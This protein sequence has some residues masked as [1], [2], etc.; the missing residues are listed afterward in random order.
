MEKLFEGRSI[1]TTGASRGTGFEII[2]YL[3]SEGAEVSIGT[4]SEERF[5]QVL[6]A[7]QQD[8][9]S[10]DRKRVHPF[11]AD[12][13]KNDQIDKAF[14]SLGKLNH[15][16]TDIIHAAA[17]G[18]P[19]KKFAFQLARLA[20]V[21][22]EEREERFQEF[23]ELSKKLVEEN[24]ELSLA[25]NYLG[26]QHL[27]GLTKNA[28]QIYLSSL[29]ATFF[30]QVWAP[31]FYEVISQPKERTIYF[32]EQES[33]LEKNGVYTTI[34]SGHIIEDT[35]VGEAFIRLVLPLMPKD[36]QKSM[37]ATFITKQD[38]VR[39]T[40]L[41]LTGECFDENDFNRRL[42]VFGPG[43]QITTELSADSPVFDY[44]IPI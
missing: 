38:M 16:I 6:Q 10:F 39:A 15:P 32:L 28:N 43:G 41:A 29:Y 33:G 42:F 5:L 34:V 26:P 3:Y 20:R 14:D 37:R 35:D 36:K 30:P 17:E 21:R 9:S 24:M 19:A 18:I 12:M 13:G 7:L 27:V 2:K 4:R 25:V 1:L 8:N 23:R 31:T 44:S 11:I 22:P 40:R